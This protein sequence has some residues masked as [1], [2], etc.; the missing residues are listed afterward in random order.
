MW[1]SPLVNRTYFYLAFACLAFNMLLGRVAKVG[2]T[3]SKR[4]EPSEIA[5][6]LLIRVEGAGVRILYN[7]QTLA[8]S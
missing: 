6:C 2:P 5:R 1:E 8:G 3:V 7:A 4:F